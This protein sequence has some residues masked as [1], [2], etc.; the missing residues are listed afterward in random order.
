MA[1]RA[2]K[3]LTPQPFIT[4]PETEASPEDNDYISLVSATSTVPTSVI[5][6]VAGRAGILLHPPLIPKPVSHLAI[7]RRGFTTR[8]HIDKIFQLGMQLAVAPA[9]EVERGGVLAYPQREKPRACLLHRNVGCTLRMLVCMNTSAYDHLPSLALF[10]SPHERNSLYDESAKW[11][12]LDVNPCS[13]GR[14]LPLINSSRLVERRSFACARVHTAPADKEAVTVSLLRRGIRFVTLH[15]F[16]LPSLPV[17]SSHMI[18]RGSFAC[19]R[20]HTA[21]VSG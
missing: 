4:L 1:L 9:P 13:L 19:V 6:I 10:I 21:S 5:T 20:L 3:C 17:I 16:S 15:L 12:L 8:Q 7:F 11:R 18:E 2:L 14:S